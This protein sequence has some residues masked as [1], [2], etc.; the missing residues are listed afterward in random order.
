MSPL[1]L[2]LK[3]MQ[4]FY[5]EI[6]LDAMRPLLSEKLIFQGPFAEF[7]TASEY[8]DSLKKNPPKDAKYK[9][10]DVYE[11]EN[12][13]CLVYEFSK[14]GLSTPMTQTFEVVGDKIRKIRLIFDTK[15]FAPPS[16]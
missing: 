8:F 11:N 12:S 13:V 10:L 6:P 2:A 1:K 7:N 4:S 14:P 3:Y 15:A 9:I 5:G 16:I